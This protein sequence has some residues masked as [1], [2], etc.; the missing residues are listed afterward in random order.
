MGI[1]IDGDSNDSPQ[2]IAVN[3]S[4]E[5]YVTYVTCHCIQVFTTDGVFLRAWGS[6]GSDDGQF[7]DP[8]GIAIDGLG[9]VS[10]VDRGNLRIQVF[11]TDGGFLR[12]W[13][14]GD[15]LEEPIGA[16]SGY[17]DRLVNAPHSIAVALSGTAYV[18]TAGVPIPPVR[19]LDDVWALRIMGDSVE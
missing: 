13:D 12:K 8:R 11:T 14:A 4:G 9:R 6:K 15:T 16:P 1:G 10:V 5:V 17:Y 18:A 19:E 3:H 7:D 2:G